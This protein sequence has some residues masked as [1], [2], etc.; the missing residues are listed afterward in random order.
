MTRAAIVG[1]GFIA[2][3]HAQVLK[4]MNVETV[5]VVAESQAEAS[6]FAAEYG[7]GAASDDFGEIFRYMPDCVHICTPPSLHY[8]QLRQLIEKGINVFCEKPLCLTVKEA[9]DITRLAE[10]ENVLTGM[11][12][13]VR[14][15]TGVQQIRY[16]IRNNEAGKLYLVHGTYLQE[17][18]VMP[19]P[20]GWR[21]QSE[22]AGRM[23]A[24]TEI[25]SHWMDLFEY[26]TGQK[27]TEVSSVF[28][29]TAEPRTVKDGMLVK[30]EQGEKTV[31]VDTEDGAL[32][33]FRTD[34]GTTGSIVLSE[35]SAGRV[36]YLSMEFC[37][38]N[39]TLRWNSEEPNTVYTGVLHQG[40]NAVT[41]P[42]AGGFA[43]TQRKLFRAFY[44]DLEGKGS[45]G[46]YPTLRDG[47]RNVR[48][49]EAVY[50][51][52]VSGKWCRTEGI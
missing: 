38:E 45:E 19:C 52:A 5:L 41:D 11:D 28:I 46:T 20:Y 1:A 36:N 44:D 30:A 25:G 49:C 2:R 37:G 4:E 24:V 12:F 47:L 48:L 33:H 8:E 39:E 43:D 17:F 26:I 51:S 15:H 32:I 22:H 35:I 6:A 23:R 21:Y 7:I 34:Q 10:D 29:K 3:T 31:E 40:T 42:F 16:R 13:N 27:I 14:Y 50:Q 18:H 9:E